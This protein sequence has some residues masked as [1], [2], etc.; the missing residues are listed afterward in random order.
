VGFGKDCAPLCEPRTGC[1]EGSTLVE[2]QNPTC[3]VR[4]YRGGLGCCHHLYYLTDLNQS[5]L[6]PDDEQVYRMKTRFYFQEYN[7]AKHQQLYRWHW[8]TAMGSG[9][10]DVPQCAPGTPADQ[11]THTINA[12]IRVSD[13]ANGPCDPRSGINALT[14][15]CKPN[16]TGFKPIFLG[17]HW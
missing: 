5:H 10:Y 4:A 17:G 7:P 6:I 15:A 9:E 1:T 11:C 16:S 3:D 13:F 8:Q 2:Q 12:T 14:P